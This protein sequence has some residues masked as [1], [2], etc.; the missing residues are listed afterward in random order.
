MLKAS[1]MKLFSP[2]SAS[3]S[4]SNPENWR[5][6]ERRQWWLSAT[7]IVVSLSLTAGILSF[8]LPEL[9]PGLELYSLD[10]SVAVHALAGIILVFDLYVVFQQVQLYR[11]R[12][13]ISERE[14]LFRLIM[15]NAADMIAVVD[16][17]GNRLYNS[18]SY[19]KTLGYS[20][21]ELRQTKGFEQIHPDDRQKVMEAA[22]E[23]KRSGVGRNL[24]YRVR[25]KDGHWV[26]ILDRGKVVERGLNSFATVC[27]LKFRGQLD[28]AIGF[29]LG[30]FGRIGR[31]E[32]S[33][34]R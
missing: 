7:G 20:P 30:E 12:K 5:V 27:I 26:W 24:E 29:F 14:E 3:H 2:G 22:L 9:I 4:E 19:Q 23:A 28:L 10:A 13:Q 33:T 31:W 32:D 6:I 34:E 1:F 15:E 18:P 17:N 21:E 8:V 11:V 16:G 25:H